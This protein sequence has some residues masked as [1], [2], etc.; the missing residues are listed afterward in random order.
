[1]VLGVSE[2]EVTR[3][4]TRGVGFALCL[5]PIEGGSWKVSRMLFEYTHTVLVAG[6]HILFAVG[7]E[8]RLPDRGQH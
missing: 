8:H 7:E 2:E 3:K 6:H 1:M 4:P 5:W